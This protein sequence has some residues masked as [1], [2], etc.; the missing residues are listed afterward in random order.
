[1]SDSSITIVGALGRDPELRFTDGGQPSC[2]FSLAVGNRFKRGD[3]W[4]EE[5]AWMNVTAW[6][7]LAENIAAS[8]IKG[9]RMIVTGTLREENWNDR[10][11]GQARSKL[12][13]RAEHAGPELRWA[14]CQIERVERSKT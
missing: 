10:E 9:N 4:V 2:S 14:R 12:V 13:L 1:M 8:C 3:E 5:T 6:G 7:T 11:T